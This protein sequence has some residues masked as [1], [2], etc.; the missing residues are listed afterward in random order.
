VFE[1]TVLAAMSLGGWLLSR[2][3]AAGVGHFYTFEYCL[4]LIP[5]FKESVP[6]RVMSIT[7][8]RRAHRRQTLIGF[9]MN[10]TLISAPAGINSSDPA[11]APFEYETESRQLRW[12]GATVVV[13]AD[14]AAQV[15]RW[16]ELTLEGTQN[17][18]GALLVGVFEE[19]AEATDNDVALAALDAAFS[20]IAN[21]H[22]AII[23][24]HRKAR[25]LA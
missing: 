5:K 22:R 15:A 7:K 11:P 20:R 12:N 13:P 23:E 16:V 21:A 6:I 9:Q 14:Q 2:H 4:A 8:Q 19:Q 18:G 10:R 3:T 24:G 1:P 25:G 17:S